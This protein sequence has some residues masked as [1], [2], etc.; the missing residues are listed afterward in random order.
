MDAGIVPLKRLLDKSLHLK[1]HETS[2]FTAR[3]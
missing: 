3:A 1:A 2:K